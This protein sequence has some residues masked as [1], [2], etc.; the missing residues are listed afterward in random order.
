M[1]KLPVNAIIEWLGDSDGVELLERVLWCDPDGSSIVVIS[2]YDP[3][4]LPI[5]RT[6]EEI[7]SAFM[8]ETALRRT[9]DPFAALAAP[10]LDLPPKHLQIRDNAWEKIRRLVT[11]EPDIYD[12]KHRKKLI[13]LDPAASKGSLD[14]VYEYL[15]RFWKR[16]MIKNALLPDYAKCGAPGNE[17]S[18]NEGVKRGRKS[19]LM[20]IDPSMTGVNV[21]DDIR[22]IF[23]IA[24]KRYYNTREQNPLRRAYDLM[25]GHH[26]NIGYRVQGEVKIPVTPSANDIPTYG[27]F[28]YWYNQ[29]IDLVHSIISRKGR[30][31]YELHHRPLLGDSTQMA[32]GPGSI[33][34]IDATIADIY[35]VS[36]FD[37]SRIIG[38]PVVYFCICCYSRMC[39]GLYVGLE[40]PSWLTGMMALANS[41]IEKVSFC[42]EFGIEI[43]AED[44]PCSFLP[45]QITA[46]RGEF[47]G[48]QSDNLVESLNVPFANCPPYR[49]DLKGIVERSF[50]RANDTSIKW[51]PGAV[52]KREQGDP[53]YR[54][55]AT[56]T[57]YEFT[58]ILIMMCIQYN[59]FHRLDKYPL[60][61]DMINDGVEPIPI[62]LWNWGIVNRSGHLREKDPDI[63]RMSLLPRDKVTVTLK[64]IHFQGMY[65]SCERAI[66]E[67]WFVKARMY[68]TWDLEAS[69]DPRK[70]ITIYL[71]IGNGVMEPCQ[72][73]PRDERYKD[74]RLEE[75]QEHQ[76]IQKQLSA[77][78]QSRRL[79]SLAELQAFTDSIVDDAYVL[80]ED[81]K[82]KELSKNARTKDIA[83]NRQEENA[84]LRD[85]EAWTSRHDKNNP[86][87]LESGEVL[88]F[89]TGEKVTEPESLTT[90]KRKNLLALIE[91]AEKG[92]DDK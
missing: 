60:G 4:T 30:R 18:I 39:V 52:R 69:Y 8:Q 85:K 5:V 22:R 37:R 36:A 66:R 68:G 54:L 32:F 55:D 50:R 81:A 25:I 61:R 3:K 88:A 19:K 27:Q 7:E 10:T 9:V 59:L 58:R 47:I 89:P 41:T 33:Y 79:Q 49:G 74:L 83:A 24:F 17:R 90:V 72:L 26:F 56:L 43:G 63:I 12:D 13:M 42:A 84:R 78:H 51:L 80:T 16:G 77:L 28:Y 31:A 6:W 70:P 44:W 57:M 76:E 20:V 2:I 46:D 14:L 67:Q 38:R 86:P 75:I 35:L 48:I 64:G 40:G 15:R 92:G 1:I 71:H 21:D 45:E 34:L 62:E 82:S 91:R 73:L 65:Y 53:D 87:E 23:N 29:Q 11:Q